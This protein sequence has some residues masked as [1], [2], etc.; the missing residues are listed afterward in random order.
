MREEKEEASMWQPIESAPKDGTLIIGGFFRQPWADSH[1]TG[2]I[3]KCW[4][5]PEFEAFISSARVMDLHNGYT[6]ED[7]STRQVHSPVVETVSHWMPLP[8]APQL[9]P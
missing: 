8:P 7:G 6:F 9:R 2:D 5:Q 1:R 3:V 4:W